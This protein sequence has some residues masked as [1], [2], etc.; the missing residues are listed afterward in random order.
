VSLFRAE[1][2]IC[3]AM[4]TFEGASEAGLSDSSDA[5]ECGQCRQKFNPE[6]AEPVKEKQS[7]SNSEPDSLVPIVPPPLPVPT[8]K[9]SSLNQGENNPPKARNPFEQLEVEIPDANAANEDPG[10]RQFVIP[11]DP[12]GEKKRGVMQYSDYR[13][14]IRRM[15][16]L[17]TIFALLLSVGVGAAVFFLVRNNAA[18]NLD[19]ENS[20]DVV[21]KQSANTDVVQSSTPPTPTEEAATDTEPAAPQETLATY[22]AAKFL[23]FTSREANILWTK[24]YPSVFELRISRQGEVVRATGTLVDSRGWIVTSYSAIKNAEQVLC[25]LAPNQIE[26][27]VNLMGVTDTCKSILAYDEATDL[28]IVQ[29]N[30]KLVDVISPL[31]IAE[32][33][34]VAGVHL[35]I[36]TPPE[37]TKVA[38]LSEGKLAQES[39]GGELSESVLKTIGDQGLATDRGW[40]VLDAAIDLLPGGTVF[41]EEGEI[42]GVVTK[43]TQG[44]QAIISSGAEIRQLMTQVGKSEPRPIGQRIGG[45]ASDLETPDADPDALELA[46]AGLPKIPNVEQL[47]ATSSRHELSRDLNLAGRRCM[48]FDW[49]PKDQTQL[50]Q[51]VDLLQKLQLAKDTLRLESGEMRLAEE[52]ALTQQV[53]HWRTECKPLIDSPGLTIINQIHAL[54]GVGVSGKLPNAPCLAYVDVVHAATLGQTASFVRIVE[55]EQ[56][57]SIPID[58]E[59]FV[60]GRGTRWLILLEEIQNTKVTVTLGNEKLTV[61]P[62]TISAA[63]EIPKR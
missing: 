44:K 7:T 26:Y 54:A 57:F 14:R 3:E 23:F 35:L 58:P 38:W 37:M 28:A 47:P 4:V 25:R 12:R 10:D 1:C 20:S 15:R 62:V 30:R 8:A 13:R 63:L 16:I 56:A 52:I 60:L 59:R 48:V 24:I 45:L 9:K 46:E 31:K 39:Y 42:H 11:A 17:F 2:P 19:N 27:N 32:K 33:P 21:S 6:N 22:G 55:G 53:N 49:I 29:I 50:G 51:V 5:I 41:S 43:G 61:N 34:P 18:A 40:M 36:A